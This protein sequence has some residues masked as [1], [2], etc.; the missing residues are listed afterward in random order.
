MGLYKMHL[1]SPNEIVAQLP[2]GSHSFFA[3][4]EWKIYKWQST[5]IGVLCQK[6]KEAVAFGCNQLTK[7]GTKTYLMLIC[8]PCGTAFTNAVFNPKTAPYGLIKPQVVP[9]LIPVHYGTEANPME[10]KNLE[11]SL[12][13][14]VTSVEEKPCQADDAMDDEGEDPAIARLTLCSYQ[15]APIP[16]LHLMNGRSTSGN[17]PALECCVKNSKKPLLLATTNSPRMEQRFTLS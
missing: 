2:I 10:T 17:P 13:W 14:V 1:C 11:G 8:F 12:L 7:D 16:S 4:D 15:S 3:P 6:F 5:H 9:K